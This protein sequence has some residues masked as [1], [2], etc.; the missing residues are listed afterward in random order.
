MHANG[1]CDRTVVSRELARQTIEREEE[2]NKDGDKI[3]QLAVNQG[4]N[5]GRDAT[6]SSDTPVLL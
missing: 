3:H 5:V 1:R 4:A 6:V 2:G